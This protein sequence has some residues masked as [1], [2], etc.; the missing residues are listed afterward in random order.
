MTDLPVNILIPAGVVIAATI[1]GVFS[2]VSLVLSKEQKVSEFRQKWIDGLREEVSDFIGNI[3]TVA[4]MQKRI[5]IAKEHEREPEFTRVDLK[6]FQAVIS[7]A[8]T[9]IVLRL[10]PDDASSI[11]KELITNLDVVRLAAQ[12]GEWEK[13]NTEVVHVR[14]SAQKLLKEE[15]DRV[16]RGESAFIWS[17]RCAFIGFIS[18]VFFGGYFL[19]NMELQDSPQL[20]NV[21]EQKTNK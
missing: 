21:I 2:F 8:Y 7:T 16:K 18:A 3:V 14:T 12:K 19:S 20:V 15:W 10:N 9:R 4:E 17:K 5:K 13:V 1:A 6:D 11:S